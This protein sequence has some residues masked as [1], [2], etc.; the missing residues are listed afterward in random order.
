ME[1]TSVK[2]LALN[3]LKRKHASKPS[4]NNTKK[5]RKPT[6]EKKFLEFPLVHS[7]QKPKALF[8]QKGI[9]DRRL[10]IF[11]LP[12]ISAVAK[13]WIDEREDELRSEG[14]I[15]N[16]L[17]NPSLQRGI[18]YLEL[19]DKPFLTVELNKNVIKF[20]W[21]NPAGVEIRQTCRPEVSKTIKNI[22]D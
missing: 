8:D 21:K 4:G 14:F 20:A 10:R 9:K 7:G 22:G 12:K 13:E 16:D 6:S 15:Q 18:A 2:S 3:V 17:Y 5:N 19:W 1:T 11:K